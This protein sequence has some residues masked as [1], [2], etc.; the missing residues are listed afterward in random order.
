GYTANI[1]TLQG[2]RLGTP[3]QVL[4]NDNLSQPGNNFFLSMGSQFGTESYIAA[5]TVEAIHGT[6]DLT[7]DNTWR[8]TAGIRWEEWIRGGPLPLDLL[9]L[10]SSVNNLITAIQD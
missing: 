3:D 6:V 1:N 4:G 2:D 5:E 10:T 8:L 7:L 9:N